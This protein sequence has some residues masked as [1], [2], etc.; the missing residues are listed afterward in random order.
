MRFNVWMMRLFL[1]R[2]KGKYH[3]SRYLEMY[4]REVDYV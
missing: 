4:K 2:G 3:V 1:E